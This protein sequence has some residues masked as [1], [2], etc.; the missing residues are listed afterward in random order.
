MAGGS[1]LLSW[2][3][4]AVLFRVLLLPF[5]PRS[6][7]VAKTDQRIWQSADVTF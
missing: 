5:L 3:L 7:G 6:T 1:V 2:L 4:L